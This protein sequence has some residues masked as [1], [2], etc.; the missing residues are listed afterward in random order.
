MASEYLTL[1]QGKVHFAPFAPGTKTPLGYDFFG[2][3]P[4]F[5]LNVSVEDLKHMT[6]T[7]GIKE[8]DASVITSRTVGGSIQC[9]DL[10]PKNLGRWFLGTSKTVTQGSVTDAVEN[11]ASVTQGLTYR[12]GVSDAAPTGLRNITV[13]SITNDVPG[14]A[15]APGAD[16][17]VN[18]E[19]GT[20]QIVNGGGIADGTNL[21]VTYDAAVSTYAQVI[22]GQTE[23]E[24]ALWFETI[25]RAGKDADY[26]MPYV[27]LRPEGD[28]ALIGDE[29]I[30]FNFT[31]TGLSLPNR[32]TLYRDDVP[33][34]P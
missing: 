21:I 12:I 24:G 15:F 2:N 16:Y 4:A 3:C 23:I 31:V 19:R 34:I 32:A 10:D 22:S 7:G 25:N 18:S 30:Q 17:I 33:M 20:I 14:P 1:G 26:L 27:K 13:D 8:E 6:S 9:D 29:W 5:S 28:L 11:I